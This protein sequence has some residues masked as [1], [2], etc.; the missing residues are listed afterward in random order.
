MAHTGKS[1]FWNS[2]Y[3]EPKRK[4]RWIL[5]IDGIPYWTVK[6][7]DKPS[8][9]ITTAEHAFI[10]HKFYFPGRMEYNEV[11]FTIVDSANPDAAE[12]LRQIIS[13][14]GYRLPK[15]DKVSTQSITK[16]G[17]VNA[18]GDIVLMQISGGGVDGQ[19]PVG[20]P[21]GSSIVKDMHKQ[22]HVLEG[23]RL[24]NAFITSVEFG[25][26]DYTSDDLNEI[27]V[28]VR[29]DYAEMNNEADFGA[30][31]LHVEVEKT[32]ATSVNQGVPAGAKSYKV[33]ETVDRQ[34]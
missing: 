27:T 22:G 4:Y 24:H 18:L 10:N 29:Y 7:V 32:F 23:W 11:S 1:G 3:T 19:Q 20:S 14:S 12:T 6:K 13:A 26:L 8:W 16:F 17:A 31:N 28:K 15:D 5:S 9:T 30:S 2:A 25:D 33:G 34:D 21:D